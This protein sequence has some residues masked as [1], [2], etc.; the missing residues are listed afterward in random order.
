MTATD[1]IVRPTFGCGQWLPR[2]TPSR[3]LRLGVKR[4]YCNELRLLL[5]TKSDAEHRVGY[6][7]GWPWCRRIHSSVLHDRDFRATSRSFYQPAFHRQMGES[8]KG[9]V[10]Q[11]FLVIPNIS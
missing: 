1:R 2:L 7:S 9:T 10:L 11:L 8:S 5:H 6:D 4:F 3:H